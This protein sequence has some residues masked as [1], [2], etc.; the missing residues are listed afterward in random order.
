[1]R[2]RDQNM[3]NRNEKVGQKL[4]QNSAPTNFPYY[5]IPWL[6]NWVGVDNESFYII[7]IPSILDP[8][9]VWVGGKRGYGR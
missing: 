1:M 7:A 2:L 9:L 6:V 4:N 8:Y 3:I 5:T